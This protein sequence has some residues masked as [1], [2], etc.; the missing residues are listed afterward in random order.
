METS[1]TMG[2]YYRRNLQS[3]KIIDDKRKTIMYDNR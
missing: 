3:S 1:R 2:L